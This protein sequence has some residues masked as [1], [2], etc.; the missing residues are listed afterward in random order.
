VNFA[1]DT[2]VAVESS[3][4]QIEDLV[5]KAGAARF[6][7]GVDLEKAYVAFELAQ[8][9][10]MFEIPMP[11]PAEFAF[12]KQGNRQVKRTKE[13]LDRALEQEKRRRWRALHLTIKAKLVSAE[14][15]IET[16]E[17]AFLAQIV[18]GVDGRATRF[19]DVAIKAIEQSYKGGNL[20]PLLG[21]GGGPVEPR[22]VNP[23]ER[24]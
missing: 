19:A 15:K 22:D 5:T 8:R 13:Q 14:S 9:R 7:R 17:E 11:Q 20:P 24:K 3:Q 18:V 2:G 6:Y 16:F 23:K 12:V 21:P 1:K 10:V 4:R